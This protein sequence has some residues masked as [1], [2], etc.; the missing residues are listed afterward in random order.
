M[1]KRTPIKKIFETSFLETS[2]N[3]KHF[4]NHDEILQ[5]KTEQK[6]YIDSIKDDLKNKK[7]FIATKQKTKGKNIA[8]D[9]DQIKIKK[10]I[11]KY[12]GV[13][14]PYTN[15]DFIQEED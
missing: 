12:L 13:K 11:E 5:V 3:G 10:R 1:S 8:L 14:I 4:S 9:Y 2:K 7:N 6:I 15:E